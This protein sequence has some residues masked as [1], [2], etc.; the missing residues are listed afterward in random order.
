MAT[1][2][3]SCYSCCFCVPKIWLR[4]LAICKACSPSESIRKSIIEF[5]NGFLTVWRLSKHG[6]LKSFVWVIVLWNFHWFVFIFYKCCFSSDSHWHIQSCFNS[7]SCFVL[8]CFVFWWKG[9]DKTKGERNWP[10]CLTLGH[11][12]RMTPGPGDDWFSS[13]GVCVSLPREVQTPPCS[14]LR[15]RRGRR[16][17]APLVSMSSVPNIKRVNCAQSI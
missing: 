16:A 13:G 4:N 7:W 9:S 1:P 14:L 11:V 2:A 3:Y 15:V 5:S 17:L 10:V 8:F 6:T 12:W